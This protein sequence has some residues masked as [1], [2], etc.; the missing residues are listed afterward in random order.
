MG[1]D[2][3]RE[4]QIRMRKIHLAAFAAILVLAPIGLAACGSSDDNS[5]DED[6]ITAAIETGA[7]STDPSKCTEVQTEN[8]ANQTDGSIKECQKNVEDAVA[9]SVDVSNI[10]VDGDK[11]TA[12]AAVTGS[13]FDGQTLQLALVKDGD[14]WKVDE[15]SGFTDFDRETFIASLLNEIKS[16][17]STPAEAVTCLEQQF[18]SATDEQL[19]G[20]VTAENESASDQLFGPCFKGQ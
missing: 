17:P 20:I 8:F 9:D 16:D 15:F 19:Q 2:I 14:Q 7:T 10:E 18:K 1:R 5:A 6:D 11:A 13:T 3:T 4:G 12:D